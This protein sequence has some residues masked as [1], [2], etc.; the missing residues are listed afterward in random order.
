MTMSAPSSMLPHGG[1]I[2]NY[3]INISHGL[4]PLPVTK[5]DDGYLSIWVA[6]M[7]YTKEPDI[8]FQKAGADKGTL[9]GYLPHLP[10][11]IYGV[12]APK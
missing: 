5:R 9:S 2:C 3:Q 11:F 6:P 12:A 4:T 8:I 10:F 7:M 1:R